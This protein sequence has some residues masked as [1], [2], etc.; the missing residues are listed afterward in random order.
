MSSV[1]ETRRY[2]RQWRRLYTRHGSPLR[3]RWGL[4]LDLGLLVENIKQNIHEKYLIFKV[5]TLIFF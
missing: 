1:P 4:S 5:N 2:H 3:S